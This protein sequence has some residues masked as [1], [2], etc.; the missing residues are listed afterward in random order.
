ML[1]DRP[2]AYKALTDLFQFHGMEPN[3]FFSR[4]IIPEWKYSYIMHHAAYNGLEMNDTRQ[5]LYSETRVYKSM[6]QIWS[7]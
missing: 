1:C 6:G 3:F 2:P 5:E 7:H 4:C